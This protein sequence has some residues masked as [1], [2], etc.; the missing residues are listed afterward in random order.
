VVGAAEGEDGGS[1]AAGGSAVLLADV[2]DKSTLTAQLAEE[3]AGLRKSRA[4]HDPGRV[5]V[6]MAVAVADGATTISDVAVLADQAA[7]FGAVASDSTCWRLLE[8]LDT[9]RLGAVGRARAA[10]REVVWAQRAELS[11]QAF[12]P[13]KAAG[14]ELPGLVI[15]LDAPRIVLNVLF[16]IRVFLVPPCRSPAACNATRLVRATANRRCVPVTCRIEQATARGTG[17]SPPIDAHRARPPARNRPSECSRDRNASAASRR[18]AGHGCG[19][20]LAGAGRGPVGEA[21]QYRQAV[22][23]VGQNVVQHEY[24]PDPAVDQ[25]GHEDGRPQRAGPRQRLAD[26]R[27][28]D[29]EQRLLVT[30]GQAPSEPHMSGGVEFRVVD[31]HRAATPER[32]PHQPLPQARDGPDPLGQHPL[33]RLDVERRPRIEH[34]HGAEMLGH[35]A[36]AL[37]R[38]QREIRRARP[39][40]GTTR[41]LTSTAPVARPARMQREPSP[42]TITIGRMCCGAGMTPRCPPSAGA[43]RGRRPP[44][45]HKHRFPGP[46]T[47]SWCGLSTG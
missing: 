23:A 15:D 13:A 38:E 24:E 1:T 21:G 2:A 9:A 34:D 12:P 16:A 31:P 8:R 6:D 5:L 19:N 32:L 14:R 46:G 40:D 18:R 25:V 47:T 36:A 29:V 42:P 39:L 11:G 3:L 20:V 30:G 22:D 35:R 10:A 26:D 41:H 4:R 33:G 37:H 7:L 43:G 45:R 27:G 28:R 17:A 44:C